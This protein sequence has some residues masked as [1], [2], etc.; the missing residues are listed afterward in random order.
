MIRRAQGRGANKF[1]VRIQETESLERVA[2]KMKWTEQP[3]SRMRQ[4]PPIT[5]WGELGGQWAGHM[6]TAAKF[7][8]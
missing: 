5:E 6:P 4:P 8:T 7:R 1:D 3:K 2:I